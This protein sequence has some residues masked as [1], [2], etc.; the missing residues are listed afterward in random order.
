M[1]INLNKL[2]CSVNISL[3]AIFLDCNGFPHK[4]KLKTISYN[5]NPVNKLFIG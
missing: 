4:S 2:V 5:N 3:H 1:E